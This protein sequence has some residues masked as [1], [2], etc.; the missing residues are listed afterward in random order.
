MAFSLETY[1]LCNK[2]IKEQIS[3]IYKYK[4]VVN[5]I[6]ELPTSAEIGDVY[7]V[8]EDGKDYAWNGSQWGAISNGNSGNQGVYITEI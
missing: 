4:G 6:S 2:K 1:A 8:S 3:S 7:N 5:K